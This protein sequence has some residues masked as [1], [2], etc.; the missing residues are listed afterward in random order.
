[1]RKWDIL[2]LQAQSGACRRK[3][4]EVV[5]DKKEVG[6]KRGF[7]SFYSKGE[8]IFNA[9]SH[10][11]GGAFGLIVWVVLMVYAYP[12][13]PAMVGVSVFSASI[14]I[15]YTMSALYHFLPDGRAK[16][17][18]RVFDHCTIY[19]LIA[20]TYT[21]YCLIPFFG[22]SAGLWV[23]VAEWVLAVAG[24]VMNA[25]SLNN[26]VVK[27]ISMTLYFIMG[28]LALVFYPL[29]AGL[30]SAASLYLLLFGGIAYTAGIVFYAFGRKVPYFHAI[31]HL[32]VI[33]GTVLQFLSILFLL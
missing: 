4:M 16:G 23:L 26:K 29:A 10:I 30:M 19:L 18:F 6:K 7:S 20:G 5:L 25:I 2:Y 8:E 28:W 27:G 13:V 1:M 3:F 14:I 17:V 12:G 22:T 32:F 9:V 21:P 31:W 24:I 15:L 33:L 11:V